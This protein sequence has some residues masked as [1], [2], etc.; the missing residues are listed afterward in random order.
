MFLFAPRPTAVTQIL[1]K[2]SDLGVRLVWALAWRAP[3][4]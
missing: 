1:S 4:D 2:D 3:K